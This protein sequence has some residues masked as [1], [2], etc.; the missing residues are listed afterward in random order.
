MKDYSILA[1]KTIF[2]RRHLLANHGV[3]RVSW[4]R[5]QLDITD[6]YK[7]LSL[8]VHSFWPLVER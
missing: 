1:D 7:F 6:I 8:V 4:V 2:D 5:L 3:A